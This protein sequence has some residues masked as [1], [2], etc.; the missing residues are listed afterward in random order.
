ME[1]FFILGLILLNGC[2]ALAELAL[3]SSRKSRLESDARHGDNKARK[4]LELSGRPDKFLSTVQIGITTIGILTGIFSGESI[5]HWLSQEIAS[6]PGLETTSDSI[7]LVI[8]VLLVTYLSLIFGELVPKRIA[9]SNP[10]RYAKM[11]A[12]PMNFISKVGIPFVWLL[13]ISTTGIM[14]I[15]GI[16]ATTTSKITE[17]EIKAILQE[18][19][20]EG[21]IQ[22][23]EHDIVERVFNLG[24]RDVNSLMTHRNEL[25]W[26]DTEDSLDEIRK[27][28]MT[29]VHN[30]YPVASEQLDEI[31]GVVFLKDFFPEF[32][33]PDF[34]LRNYIRPAQF[35]P[36]TMSGYNVLEHFKKSQQFYAIVTDEYGSIQGMVTI[37]D[38]MEA[39]VG[40]MMEPD[41]QEEQII[42]RD[43]N[44][45]LVD[46]Q[47]SFYDFLAYFDMEDL[48]QE[49]D[50]NTL[51]GLILDILEHIP[52]TA[53]KLRWKNFEME[54]V[55]MDAARI[56]KVMVRMIDDDSI[57]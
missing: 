39:L 27:S 44:S 24:D 53:E 20:D 12:G 55:D 14:K 49:H 41:E 48:Y 50:F 47:Y 19:T 17:E 32:N 29:K 9:M 52:S 23:V 43:D 1:I 46:G 22:E 16:S 56:D 8:V 6:I 42:Q 45:W 31:E 37:N 54:I 51:S 35:V 15:F 38:L 2:F 34:D 26:L 28:I 57:S 36:E 13:S 10:E 25:I 30:V 33:S 18:G 3:V 5:S 40:T 7:S 4:A 21:E 11:V